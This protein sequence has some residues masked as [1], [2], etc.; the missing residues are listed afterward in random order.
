MLTQLPAEL[1]VQ[2]Q[3]GW[4]GYQ[5]AGHLRRFLLEFMEQTSLHINFKGYIMSP[6]SSMITDVTI[7][8]FQK[9]AVKT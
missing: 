1:F 9:N 4:Q 6:R 7:Y 8:A 2:A 5:K 3:Q